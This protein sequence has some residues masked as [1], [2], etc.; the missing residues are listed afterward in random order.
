MARWVVERGR[1]GYPCAARSGQSPL[2]RFG[3]LIRAHQ[4]TGIKR[5]GV[6]GRNGPL[7]RVPEDA[8]AAGGREEGFLPN[9]R[10]A[11]LGEFRSATR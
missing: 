10:Q 9:T 3:F 6:A 11:N 4:R 8:L 1:L 5:V 2:A 7:R